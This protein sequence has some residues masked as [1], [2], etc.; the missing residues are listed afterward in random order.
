MTPI[1]EQIA[2]YTPTVAAVIVDEILSKE[3]E[4]FRKNWQVTTKS[5][6]H[7]RV[8]CA[9]LGIDYVTLPEESSRAGVYAL[10]LMGKI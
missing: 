4:A 6:F 3:D 1:L 5:I 2:K 7:D 8:L 10:Y 9:S